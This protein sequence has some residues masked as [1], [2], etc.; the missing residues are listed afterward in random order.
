MDSPSPQSLSAA[1][2]GARNV[3]VGAPGSGKTSV[4]IDRLRTLADGGVPVDSLVMLTPSRQAA[5]ALRDQVG[6]A[7]ARASRGPRVRSVASLAF[8]IVQAGHAQQGLPPPDVL[9][10]SQIDADI[11]A[12]LQGHIEDG[13][14]PAWPEPLTPVVREATAFRTELREWM[15]RAVE[16]GL[17]PEDM[18]QIAQAEDR[19]R[20]AAAADFWDEFRLVRSSSRPASFDSAEIVAR[21][22]LLVRQEC[23]APFDSLVHVC[24]DDAMDLTIAGSGS[25]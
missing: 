12:L 5:S 17:T 20:W 21:A 25:R 23:P 8:A 4:L 6:L 19:P 16:A 1:P 22:A 7:L 11:H 15:A 3:V 24:V 14:G 13:R 10:A 9:S 18:R 2:S